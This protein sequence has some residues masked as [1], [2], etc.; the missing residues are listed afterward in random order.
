LEVLSYIFPAYFG[1]AV[2]ESRWQRLGE[3]QL[4]SD[5]R[6]STTNDNNSSNSGKWLEFGLLLA[7]LLTCAVALSPNGADPDL[8]GHVQFG[9]DK[10]ANGLPATTTYSFTAEGYPWINHENLAEVVFAVGADT[11]GP[12]GL[13]LGKAVLGLLVIGLIA[14]HASRQHVGLFTI[15]LV[16]LLVAINLTFHWTV[17]PQLFSFAFYA[18]IL[19]LLAW[20]FQGWEGRWRLS[21]AERRADIESQG[22]LTYSFYRLKFLWIAPVIFFVWANSH[23]GFVAGYCIFA[24]YLVFRSIEAV[25]CKGGA[26]ARLLRHFAMMIVAAGLATFL[27]PYGLRLH[28]WLLESLS[29]PRPEIVEWHPP[30]L[31]EPQS[32]PLW[33]ILIVWM[34]SLLFTRRPRDFT[35][36]AIMTM[37]L[38]QTMEHQRHGAF[39][40]IAFGLWMPVHLESTLRRF[41]ISRGDAAFGSNIPWPMQAVL[42]LG[43]CGATTLLML[44][45]SSRL[46]DMPVEREMFPVSALTYMADRD[47]HGKLVV[48]YNWSQYAI[49]A[50]GTEQPEDEGVTVGFD[51]R[52]RTCYPQHVVDMHFDFILGDLGSAGRFRKPESS[53]LDGNRVLEYRDPDLVLLNRFQPNSPLVMEKQS[54]KWTLLYQDKVA[55]LWGRADKYDAPHHPDY[56]PSQERSITDTPQVGSVTWPALPK[57]RHAQTIAG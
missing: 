50:F 10:L 34:F 8:W 51:G 2:R 26:S 33:L 15:T 45:L 29:V 20:C 32:I 57:R 22:E 21:L 31:L 17:R 6:Y 1:A 7:T 13:L 11:V 47:L 39:F 46:G 42:W 48:T 24:A 19:A 16:I 35:H 14:R 30:A 54:E 27:N 53:P 38:W 4:M 36:M 56:I 41:N 55:Q 44:K 5:E 9:R 43:L 12:L 40:V 18:A 49:A 23:G 37:T 52:F 25:A 28:W 3:K